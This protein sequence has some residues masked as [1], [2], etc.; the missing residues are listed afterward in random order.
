MVRHGLVLLLAIC[1]SP[2]AG[3]PL[4]IDRL[5][6]DYQ[7]YYGF[8]REDGKDTVYTYDLREAKGVWHLPPVK[9]SAPGA[10]SL[11]VWPSDVCCSGGLVITHGGWEPADCFSRVVFWWPN[12]PESVLPMPQF[13][14]RVFW[15]VLQQEEKSFFSCGTDPHDRE[16]YDSVVSPLWGKRAL[17]IQDCDFNHALLAKMRE[18]YPDGKGPWGVYVEAIYLNIDIDMF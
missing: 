5:A 2:V 9:T 15:P 12:R 16:L 10:K 7:Q 18:R 13:V 14:E 4:A 3:G 8:L 17:T 11:M 1:S 6:G